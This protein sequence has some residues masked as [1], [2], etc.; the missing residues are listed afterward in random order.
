MGG[1]RWVLRSTAYC[2][3]IWAWDFGGSPCFGGWG[4]VP[5][6]RFGVV[7]EG[8]A[9]GWRQSR[10]GCFQDRKV[11]SMGSIRRD[12]VGILL[13][14]NVHFFL[15]SV[16]QVRYITVGIRRARGTWDGSRS[17][18]TAFVPC[19]PPS[20]RPPTHQGPLAS[21][22]QTLCLWFLRSRAPRGAARPGQSWFASIFRC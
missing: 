15:G 13:S 22:I 12:L 9:W 19:L 18:M 3:G 1:F 2:G 8:T 17:N 20:S 14:V 6:C 21:P 11:G 5:P 16:F 4:L 10:P 7:G